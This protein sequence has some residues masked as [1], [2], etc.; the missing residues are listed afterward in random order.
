MKRPWPRPSSPE[1][2]EPIGRLSVDGESIPIFAGDTLGA[3]LLRAGRLATR[4]SRL[5]QPRGLYCGIGICNECLLTVDGRPN[6]RACVTPASP[7][8]IVETG[9]PAT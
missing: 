1:A 6:M 9:I 7:G 3:C 5:G 2:G 8:A 4:R